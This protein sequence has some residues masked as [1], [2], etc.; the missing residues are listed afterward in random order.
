M[1]SPS[2]TDAEIHEV[3]VPNWLNSVTKGF[4]IAGEMF[5]RF[6]RLEMFERFDIFDRLP[7]NHFEKDFKSQLNTSCDFKFK[8]FLKIIVGG[9]TEY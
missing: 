7:P 6:E 9:F 2:D 1:C 5:E 3:Y 4:K 8:F